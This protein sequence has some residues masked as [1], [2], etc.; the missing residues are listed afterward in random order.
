MKPGDK[1]ETKDCSKER[2]M[3]VFFWMMDPTATQADL[4]QIAPMNNS[5]AFENAGIVG[6]HSIGTDVPVFGK[7]STNNCTWSQVPGIQS[8]NIAPETLPGP[9]SDVNPS[10]GPLQRFCCRKP[11]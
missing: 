8:A 10:S 9:D 6:E 2:L 1:C 4:N 11:K 3:M 5:K 7:P